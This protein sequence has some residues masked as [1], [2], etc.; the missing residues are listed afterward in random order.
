MTS[1]VKRSSDTVT[2]RKWFGVK[3]SRETRVLGIRV[4]IISF[5]ALMMHIT[6][7]SWVMLDGKPPP[8]PPLAM[9]LSI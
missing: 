6:V 3:K 4:S 1:I 9:R 5:E 7:L 8:L 2:L